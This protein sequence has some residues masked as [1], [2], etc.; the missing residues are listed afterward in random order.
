MQAKLR[1]SLNNSLVGDFPIESEVTTL[2]RE[3][4][5]DIE[6]DD[7]SVSDRHARILSMGDEVFLEDLQSANGT[8]VNGEKFSKHLLKSGDVIRL[9]Q[10]EIQFQGMKADERS[11]LLQLLSG[12]NKGKKMAL[13][14]SITRLGK[15]GEKVA[16]I[17]KRP[18]GYFIMHLAS[19]PL[20]SFLNGEKVGAKAAE[21]KHGDII[22]VGTIRMKIM[23]PS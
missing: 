20:H 5:N 12:P 21:L 16:A 2:G 8:Y 14:Q 10:F 7:L 1:I 15:S 17:A 6:L 4:T 22:E 13:T 11:A 19:T 9:G 23:V 3:K 18:Q